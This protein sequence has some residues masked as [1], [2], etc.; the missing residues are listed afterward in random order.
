M[1][2]IT[3]KS[4]IVSLMIVLSLTQISAQD[5]VGF[6]ID[7]LGSRYSDQ[8]YLFSVP[9]CTCNFDNGWDGFKMIGTNSLAPII[10]AEEPGGK[11]QVDAIPDFNETQIAFKAGEDSEY[12]LSFFTQNLSRFYSSLYLVDLVENKT[13]NL[14]TPGITYT[15]SVESTT[16][17]VIRFKIITQ[18]PVVEVPADTTVIEDPVID[19]ATPTPTDTIIVEDP[20][21][22]PVIDPVTPTPTD[23]LIVENPVEDPVITDPT[24]NGNGDKDKKDKKIKI[25]VS[26]KHISIENDSDNNGL[27]RIMD[28]KIGMIVKEYTFKR[29]GTT[30]IEVNVSAGIYVI[31]AATQ[32][33]E[34]SVS[35]VF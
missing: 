32:E 24:D 10:Y 12:I 16:A 35:T 2:T 28:A 6:R 13:I 25:K 29:D 5:L 7:V 8:L 14:M 3:L 11:F 27:V 4:V 15:F 34:T 18:L 26:K 22:D 1:K 30:E 31:Q 21:I 23:T 17:P 19:P 9:T 20:I 33:E